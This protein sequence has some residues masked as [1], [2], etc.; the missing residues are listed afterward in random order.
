MVADSRLDI[1][2]ISCILV[3]SKNG[4]LNSCLIFCTLDH[5]FFCAKPQQLTVAEF[6]TSTRHIIQ[7]GDIINCC[8][9]EGRAVPCSSNARCAA[10]YPRYAIDVLVVGFTVV[11]ARSTCSSGAERT[12]LR[13]SSSCKTSRRMVSP[14]AAEFPSSKAT[15]SCRTELGN[16][17]GAHT[18]QANITFPSAS[19]SYVRSFPSPRRS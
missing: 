4:I 11:R 10:D 17:T 3:T 15:H 12:H 8:S 14:C 5:N 19:Q 1:C 6:Y 7:H 9:V 13:C 16:H 18:L 2:S